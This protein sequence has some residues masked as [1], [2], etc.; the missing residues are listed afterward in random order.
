MNKEHESK[1][2]FVGEPRLTTGTNN[3]KLYKEQSYVYNE[4]RKCGKDLRRCKH[5]KRNTDRFGKG[6]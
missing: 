3:R 4:D 6:E 5:V 2:V 1:G